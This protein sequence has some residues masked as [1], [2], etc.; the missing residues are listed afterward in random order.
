MTNYNI[1]ENNKKKFEDIDAGDIF[2]YNT[3][4]FLKTALIEEKSCGLNNAVFLDE[5]DFTYFKG[6]IEVLVVRDIDIIP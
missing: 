3:N 5:G 2:I 1:R 4:L 6:D